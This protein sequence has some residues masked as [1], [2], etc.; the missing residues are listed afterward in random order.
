MTATPGADISGGNASV[1][2]AAPRASHQLGANIGLNINT[3]RLGMGSAAG[4]GS[5]YPPFIPDVPSYMVLDASLLTVGSW[6]RVRM[7]DTELTCLAC[8]EM[9]QLKPVQRPG[10]HRPAELDSL[11]GEF[12]WI[13]S[14]QGMRYKMVLPYSAVSRIK[15]REVPDSTLAL[16]DPSNETV[17]NPQAAIALLN[18]AIRNPN[19]RGEMSI[20]V[21]DPPKYYFQGD[22]G[23]W[24][25]IEDFSEN[26][27]ASNSH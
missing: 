3:V 5:G 23:G 24:K 22:D 7:Q 27:S 16:I 1:M 20:H 8:V 17:T 2:M 25:E 21:Y 19:A 15:F 13:I 9:P 14:N 6:Q 10:N 12:Q 11:V 4:A 18:Q 26:H